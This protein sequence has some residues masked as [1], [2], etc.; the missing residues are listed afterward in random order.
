MGRQERKAAEARYTKTHKALHA[1]Q[2][3]E[4]AAGVDHETDTYIELNAAAADAARDP[5]LGWWHRSR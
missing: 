2:R 3:A 5:N 4:E 1:N